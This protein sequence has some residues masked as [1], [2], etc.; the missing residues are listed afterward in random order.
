MSIKPVAWIEGQEAE[1]L[2]IGELAQVWPCEWEDA[3]PL[4][5][6]PDTHRLVSVEDLEA[7]YLLLYGGDSHSP[8]PALKIR[9]IIES[10]P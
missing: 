8:V 6:I 3:K 5:Y 4:H 1:R 9:A 7:I 10:R 2:K